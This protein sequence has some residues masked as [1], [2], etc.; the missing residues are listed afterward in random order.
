MYQHA[1]VVGK[2]APLHRGHQFLIETALAKSRALTVL[3]YAMP[4]FVDMPNAMRCAWIRALYPTV[5]CR[6]PDDP[7][8]D[9]AS[10]HDHRRF[11]RDYLAC[12]GIVVDAVFS[13]EAYGPGFARELGVGHVM[14]DRLRLRAPVSGS[15]LRLSPGHAREWLHPLVWQAIRDAGDLDRRG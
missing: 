10:E 3:V 7:P 8:L 13:S 15:T 2:F 12:E 14:V 4:D 5:D 6:I 9:A 11:V 1:L